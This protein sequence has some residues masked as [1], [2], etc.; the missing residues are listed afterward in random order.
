MAY[1]FTLEEGSDLVK[2]L[3][4]N[5]IMIIVICVLYG[6][7]YVSWPQ[8]VIYIISVILSAILLFDFFLGCG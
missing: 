8:K 7:S 4:P 1:L 2:M 5:L 6:V 3:I